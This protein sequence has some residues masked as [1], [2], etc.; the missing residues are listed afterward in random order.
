MGGRGSEW[1]RGAELRAGLNHNALP[2]TSLLAGI[3]N[4]EPKQFR[5][6]VFFSSNLL[7][8]C[9]AIVIC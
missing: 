5:K 7:A 2:A 4:F 8:E 1:L 6:K 3:T 9:V